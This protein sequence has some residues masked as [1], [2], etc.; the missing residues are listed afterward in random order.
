MNTL[1]ALSIPHLQRAVS[2]AAY[3]DIVPHLG[4]PHTARVADQRSQ[5]LQHENITHVQDFSDGAYFSY[6]ALVQ[7]GFYRQ[8][9]IPCQ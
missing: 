7:L 9:L 5:A 4:R 6:D 2:R 1:A 8:I 3:N